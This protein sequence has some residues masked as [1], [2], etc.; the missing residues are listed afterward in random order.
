MNGSSRLQGL[1]PPSIQRVILAAHALERGD[2]DEAT[3]QLAP[4]LTTHTH[5]PEVLRLQAGILSQR[6]NHAAAL[7][8]M[9]QALTLRADDPLYYNTLGSILGAGDDLDGAVMALHHA[10]ELQP[11]LA[12]AWYNLGVMLTHC[13]RHEDA[14]DALRRAVDL[15]PQHME[16]RAL[17]S[18]MLRTQGHVEEAQMLYWQILAERPTSGMA[19]WGLADIKTSQFDEDDVQ[20]MQRAITTPGISVDDAVPLGFALA[21]ALDDH[22]RYAESIAALAQANA[23]A[24]SREQWSAAE[25]SA[26]VS[27]M[28][29]TFSGN[30]ATTPERDLG[31][32]V[33]FV[34][35][36]P[37][38]GTTL[39][40]QI[41]A[42]H[43]QVQGAGELPDLPLTLTAESQRRGIP[44]PRWAQQAGA[45]DWTRLGRRYMERTARWRGERTRFIDKLPSNWMYIGAIRSMLPA[46]RIVACRRDPLESCFS[47]YRQFLAGNEY[48]RTF[49]DLAAFWRDFDRSVRAWR[50]Y[51][52]TMLYEHSYEQLVVHPEQGI[53]AL[54]DFCAL[55]FEETCLRFYENKREVRSP[56][57]TQVRQP[58]Q[59]NRARSAQYGALLDPLRAALGLTPFDQAGAPTKS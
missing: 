44:F 40:E 47:C 56:S 23:T 4:V 32:E 18:D 31:K 9:R 36:L 1:S 53:R 45:G 11:N 57:A 29:E 59:Q 22:G 34:I 15:N 25:F 27:S 52:P 24:R 6:G 35:G 5:H 21:K 28:L 13:V 26:G 39:V 2:V 55:P 42:S 49:E 58:I 3:R 50:Q 14:I 7:A 10:C 41:L 54:L 51:A 17:L 12:V 8:V 37:R 48:A 46:A 43:S 19:W 20:R 33:I 30:V 38:S 16:A